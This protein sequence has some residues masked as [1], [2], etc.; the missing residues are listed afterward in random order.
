MNMGDTS[1][2]A[3]SSAAMTAPLVPCPVLVG[4][5]QEAEQLAALLVATRAGRGAVVFIVGEAGIGKSR[6]VQETQALAAASGMRILRGRAVSGS[7]A[8]P[9]RPLT[10]ALVPVVDDA[11]LSGDLGPWLPT[12]AAVLPTVPVADAAEASAPV[13][14]EAIL[15][16]LENLCAGSGGLLVLEDLHWA[17]LGDD[18]GG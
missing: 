7:G 16:L 17:D 15:R 2:G 5:T 1:S 11:D 13:R 14:G 8:A 10:E 9:F 4:R 3:A 18:R 6:L 12:L